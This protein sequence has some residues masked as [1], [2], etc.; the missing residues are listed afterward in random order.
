M[1]TPADQVNGE[2]GFLRQVR[3]DRADG[4]HEGYVAEDIIEA[5]DLDG[6]VFE[7]PCLLHAA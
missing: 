3:V 1:D 6:P 5:D 2:T 7:S 4:L